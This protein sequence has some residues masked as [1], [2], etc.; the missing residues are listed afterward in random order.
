MG[1]VALL[2]GREDGF[3][4]RE[5]LTLKDLAVKMSLPEYRVRAVINKELQYRNFNEFIN[6]Y[7]IRSLLILV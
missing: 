6:E 4:R 2:R 5:N 7:R 3:Y 1:M